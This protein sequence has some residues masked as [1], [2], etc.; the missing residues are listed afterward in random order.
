MAEGTVDSLNIQLSA[1]ADQAVKSLKSLASTLRSINSAFT[2][3]ISGMRKFSKELGTMTA[4]LRGLNNIKVSAPDL[5]KISKA[6]K[7]LSETKTAGAKNTANDIKD[8]INSLRG[9]G[10]V[11]FNESGITKLTNS[12]RRLTQVDLSTFDASKFRQITESVSTLGNMPD[13]S[14]SVNR[15][16]SS[17]SRLANAGTKTGQSANDILRLGQQTAL[18]ARELGS[19]GS[20]NDDVNMFVQSIGRLATAGNKTAQTA[21]GLSTLSKETIEFFKAMQNAPKVSQNTIAMTQALAQLASAGGRVGTATN[22]V[23]SAF[24]KLS[25]AGTSTMNALKKASSG[26][27]SALQRITGAGKGVNG[28]TLSLGNLLKTAVGFNIGYGLLNFGKSMFELGSDITEVENVVDVAFGGMSDKAYEFAQTAKEQFGLSELV[29]LRYS[30]TMMSVLNSSGVAQRDAAEMSTTL[31]GLAGDIA[32][33]YNISQ[34]NAWEKIMSGMAGEIEPLRRLGINMSVANMEAYALSQGITESWQSMSQAE[35]V[36]LRYNYLMSTTTAQQGDFARTSGTWAN[37]VRLLTLNIQQLAST[38][39]QG[40]ISAVLPAV[41]ALNKLFTVLQKAAVAVRNFFYVLTGYEGGGSSGIVTDIS[42]AMDDIADS[43]GAAT[44]GIGDAADAAEDLKDQLTLLPFDQINKLSDVSVGDT[45]SGGGTGGGIGDTGLGDIDD[46]LADLGEKDPEKYVSPWAER[47]REAFLAE[48]WEGLGAEIADG[49]NKGL[50]KV[51]DVINW[52][53]VGP[54]ITAFTTA[55]T[56]TFNSLVDNFDWDLLGRTIGAGINTAVNTVNQLIGEGGIN[57]KAIGSKLSVGLRGA[58]NEIEWEYLGNMLGNGFMISWNLLDG[59]V[60]DMSK[61]NGAGITGWEELGSSIGE[62]LKGVF[63]KIDFGTIADVFVLGF[64]GIFDF[65]KGFNAEKP[66]EGLGTKIS[67]A[68]NTIIR[69]LDPVAAGTAISDF[70]TGLLGEFVIIAEQ[71]DWSEFGR[72][73]G[74]LLENIDWGTILTQIGTILSEVFGGLIDG[75]SETTVGKILIFVGSMALAFKGKSVLGSVSSLVSGISGKFSGLSGIFGSSSKQ[76]SDAATALGNAT[77]TSGGFLDLFGGKLKGLI[78]KF[79]NSAVATGGFT[80]LLEGMNDQAKAVSGDGMLSLQIALSQLKDQGKITD[81]Q[82][83]DIYSTLTTAQAKG[84]EFDDSMA[85]VR[86]A[87]DEAGVSSEEFEGTL[88]DT[89]DTLGV[90]SKDKAKII[91]AGIADGTKEGIEE[92]SDEVKKSTEGIGTKI[93]NW[94]KNLLG[95]NS[96]STVFAEIGRNIIQ[97]LINGFSELTKNAV[98]SISNIG[99]NI[100]TG[101]TSGIEIDDVR[102][103]FNNVLSEIE[104]VF[105]DT[106]SFFKNVFSRSLQLTEDAFSNIDSWFSN[107]WTQIKN[108]FSPVPQVFQGWFKDA[109]NRTNTAWQDANNWFSNKWSQIKNVFSPVAST[110]KGWFQNAYSN[111]QNIWNGVGNWFSE[112]WNS[113]KN[114][115]GNNKT[116]DFFRNAFKGAYDAVT[117][118]WNNIGS[119]FKDIANKAISPINKLIDGIVDGINW[120]GGKLGVGKVVS[121]W[122]YIKFAKGSDGVPRNMMGVV[123]DQKG[124]TYKELIVPPSGKPFIPKGRNVMLPLQKGTKIMPAGQTKELMKLMKIHRFA[125][126]IGDFFGGAWEKITNI[127]GSIWDYVQNP[128][129]IVQI[130]INKF[131]DISDMVEPWFSIAGGT[132]KKLMDNIVEFVKGLFDKA[133]PEVSY[134]PSGGVEQWRELAAKALQMTGQYSEANLNRLLMQMQ[135]ESGGNP[136]AINNWDINAK[137]GTPSKGLMQVIDP[138][139]QAYKMPGYNNIWDPLSNILA[140]IRYTLSRYGSLA[141]GWQGHGYAEGVGTITFADLFK[142]I[143]KLATGGLIQAPTLAFTGERFR[144][145]AVLPLENRRTMG[146]IAN[147]IIDNADGSIGLSKNEL[148]DAVSQGVAMAMM[149]SKNGQNITVYAEL[150]TENDEV[151]ARAVTRGQQKL[152]YR[153]KPVSQIG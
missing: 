140:A 106:P 86:N 133:I 74:E 118:V 50:Q 18:A 75:L 151:L 110:F 22:S 59:F 14:S 102:N 142:G 130:A 4:A 19:V 89:L 81:D 127:A 20:I 54:K 123:N 15:L 131:A 109:R 42:T 107:K 26:I 27:V 62:A 48:D 85:Y 120:I 82:F 16:V 125:G 49:L 146:L 124:A 17:L 35:Q 101:I 145:E 95:I 117:K 60:L 132:I 72:K 90:S 153:F 51:Y 56:Q 122:K 141:R 147:S 108:V 69:N 41:T 93:I 1:D 111:V 57:F 33:F 47:I 71:T 70:V 116:V 68:L 99:E 36:M 6:M 12:L 143:P 83:N 55:F 115:F 94:F 92:K 52:R 138:T 5:S 126:G 137:R 28:L 78:G 144:K 104:N 11:N 8:I 128:E 53:N 39:G 34:D 65:L 3:D 149:N 97:G 135:T 100:I 129:K 67:T 119:F 63:E 98:D 87:L 96:P 61:K 37:Q 73:I 2:K 23:T 45:G 134:S 31:A 7:E 40:L 46:G 24:E 44:G 9:L 113:V 76:A 30:G 103:T 91:G 32:S 77:T 25:K 148:R 38:I 58:V 66:F 88:S 21:S 114:I 29:A 152:D 10:T 43:S 80:A 139:F 79:T 150:K 84:I 121:D 112:K 13:V 64:N 105:N 136:N